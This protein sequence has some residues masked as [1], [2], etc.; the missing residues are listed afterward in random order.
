MLTRS[1]NNDC[2][3]TRDIFFYRKL[4]TCHLKTKK[5]QNFERKTW[6]FSPENLINSEFRQISTL[7][8][9][10]VDKISEKWMLSYQRHFFDRKIWNFSPE[11]PKNLWKMNVK[12]AEMVLFLYSL[13]VCREPDGRWCATRNGWTI[14]PL[15]R[16]GCRWFK[17]PS[18]RTSR[19]SR[20]ATA[21]NSPPSTRSWS[22][23]CRKPSPLSNTLHSL[24]QCFPNFKKKK[25]KKKKKKWP[26]GR[27]RVRTLSTE[28]R[29]AGQFGI[30]AAR[31]PSL[32]W[33]ER[34]TRAA[35]GRKKFADPLKSL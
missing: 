8:N 24:Q 16:R 7:T 11:N 17:V 4:K 30:R 14:T 22:S 26:A 29:P 3:V 20:S 31:G 2:K 32:P 23:C 33:F 1:V 35:R 12:L 15:R 13:F 21:K 5:N 6:N 34:G 27:I 18:T 9:R 10:N 19:A 25:K 28:I